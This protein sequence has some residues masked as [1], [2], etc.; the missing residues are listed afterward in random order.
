MNRN[1]LV[2]FVMAGL[3]GSSV[4][5]AQPAVINVTGATLLENFVTNPSSTRDV[6]DVDGDGVTLD[7]NSNLRDQLAPTIATP[8]AAFGASTVDTW[9]LHYRAV[10]SVNGL[11]ELLDSG[12]SFDTLPMTGGSVFN[13][14]TGAWYNRTRFINNAAIVSGTNANTANP[15]S[16]FWRTNTPA[17]G[18]APLAQAGTIGGLRADV[19]PLDVP[20]SWAV[21]ST[22]LGTPSFGRLP[23]TLGYGRNPA[24]PRTTSGLQIASGNVTQSGTAATTYNFQLAPLGTANLNTVSP[25]ANTLFETQL[26]FAVV[27]PINNVGTGLTQ[28]TTDDL[29]HL[30]MTGRMPSGINFQA[31]TRSQG[32]GT[33][34]AMMNSIGLDPSWAQGERLGFESV[35]AGFNQAGA[36]FQPGSKEGSGGLENTVTNNRLAIGYTGGE[37]F[38]SRQDQ[39]QLPSIINSHLGGNAPVRLSGATVLTNTSANT[40]R[41]GGPAILASFG[42][43]LAEPIANGGTGVA[44]PRLRNPA[45]AAYLNNVRTSIAQVTGVDPIAARQSPGEV[46]ATLYTLPV[47]QSFVQFPNGPTNWV[48]NTNLNAALQANLLSGALASSYVYNNAAFTT[49]NTTRTLR[50]PTRATGPTYTDGLVGGATFRNLAGV[51]VSYNNEGANAARNRIAGDFNNDGLRNN[52]DIPGMIAAWR[53]YNGGP[54]WDGVDVNGG[55]SDT[56]AV[57]E[58]LGDFNSDGNFNAADVRYFADGLSVVGGNLD[59]AA[60]FTA[61]DNAFGGNFFGTTKATGAAYVNGDSRADVAGN[62]VTTNN[63]GATVPAYFRVAP[64]ASPIGADGVINGNDICYVTAQF[65]DDS[66]REIVWSNLAEAVNADLSAD[67]NGDRVINQADVDAIFTM[68]GTTNRDINLDGVANAADV[69]IVDANLGNTNACF[70]DGDANGDGAVTQADRDIV[71]GI[72]QCGGADIGSEGG[73]QG[74]DGVLDNNDFIVFIDLFFGQNPAAD[75]GSEGGAQGADGIFDNNDFIVFIGLFFAGCP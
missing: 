30:F 9:I 22:N 24:T 40:W 16:L 36:N 71:A 59:R 20:L 7:T 41:I 3:A 23:A 10:G 39:Y 51:A 28:L 69:A 38:T 14:P 47:T 67:I 35:A 11:R 26:A 58:I 52:N 68:L 33:H 50:T 60:G 57:V 73:A 17:D 29:R 31:V 55:A 45:A 18:I 43:P 34:N 6:I 13:A 37:R 56:T 72:T 21:Q 62:R 42:N 75:L 70:Q 5:L 49:Y 65:K 32:S 27:A 25:D 53:G 46:A 1:A 4:A 63:I 44:G 12:R 15:G 2:L 19:A 64:G 74:F 8:P 61:V 54:S 48:A 66:N